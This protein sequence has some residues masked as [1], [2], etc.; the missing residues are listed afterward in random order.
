[1]RIIQIMPASPGTRAVYGPLGPDVL[2]EPV[3]AFALCEID[4]VQLREPYRA[5]PAIRTVNRIV[6]MVRD[7]QNT[8]A[9]LVNAEY[10]ANFIGYLAPD[11]PDTIEHLSEVLYSGSAQ[12][13]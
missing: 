5:E 7:A 12:P 9:R 11:E 6:G 2:I 1:M 4:E 3:L 10:E 8:S 13:K